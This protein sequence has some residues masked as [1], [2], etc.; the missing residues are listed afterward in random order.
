[1]AAAWVTVG[2]LDPGDVVA[3]AQCIV[4]DAE[5]FPYPSGPFGSSH[6][7]LLAW[8]ARESA[9]GRVLGFAAG[10]ARG[11]VVYLQG[12]AVDRSHHR[13][14]VGRGLVREVLRSARLAGVHTVSLHVSVAN[15]AAIGL[16]GSEGFRAVRRLRDF[17]SATA[18]DG[19]RDALEM[20]IHLGERAL[21]VN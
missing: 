10:Q 5:A 13:R 14:G 15:R 2:L 8:V 19:E 17:Y 21:A 12:L 18:F 3:V 4:I 20:I 7:S 9:D 16:Y 1:M 6:P 11:G